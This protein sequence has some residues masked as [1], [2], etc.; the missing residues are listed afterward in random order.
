MNGSS[1]GR[2][3]TVNVTYSWPVAQP[4]GSTALL[5]QT[6]EEGCIAFRVDARAIALIRKQLADC[7]CILSSARVST[8]SN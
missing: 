2:F 4:D 3:R 1:G 6:K 7:E 8:Y 5:L